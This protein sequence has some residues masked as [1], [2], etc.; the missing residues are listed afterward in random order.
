MGKDPMKKI[1]ARLALVGSVMAASLGL[2]ATPVLA[3][4]YTVIDL[5]PGTCY[6]SSAVL[7]WEVWL[8][9]V[10]LA[11][12]SR[13]LGTY[14]HLFTYCVNSNNI[15]V[16][17]QSSTYAY[18]SGTATTAQSNYI[19]YSGDQTAVAANMERRISVYSADSQHYCVWYLGTKIRVD[20]NAYGV[21]EVV[22]YLETPVLAYDNSGPAFT[23]VIQRYEFPDG[24][25]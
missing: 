10:S 2:A 7:D 19:S 6:T 5:N 14:R 4:A 16:A 22:E 25:G 12:E 1:L 17:H 21:H 20:I 24:N 3:N 11:Y 23:C 15:T 8:D 13:K 18:V 9:D